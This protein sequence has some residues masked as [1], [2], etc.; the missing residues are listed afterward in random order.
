MP[1]LRQPV[2]PLPASIYWR[3]R[4]VVL[5]ALAVVVALM[6]WLTLGQGGGNGGKEK[7]AQPVPA[8]ST[9]PSPGSITP[10]A[11]PTGPAISSHPGGSSGGTGSGSAVGGSGS[12][13]SGATSGSGAPGTPGSTSGGSGGTTGGSGTTGGGSSGGDGGGTPPINT[14]DVLALPAC[15]ASQ[16]TLQLAGTQD[17]YQAK[18]KPTFELKIHNVST[19]TCRV[20][21]GQTASAITVSSASGERFW[22][23]ADCA[24]DKQSRWV[25]VSPAD[26]LTETFVW[27]RSHSQPQCATP[28]DTS[29]APVGKYSV[30]AEL[31]GPGGGPVKALVSTRLDS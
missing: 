3:R 24:T 28:T 17:A 6:G 11:T 22:S 16:L 8:H 18:D 13:S 1:S 26:V 20:D 5:A 25:Q 30:Q 12:G 21:L 15:T 14:G 19:A 31:T 4:V 29:P 7:T 23:S 9:P 27:D 2:G 10:G